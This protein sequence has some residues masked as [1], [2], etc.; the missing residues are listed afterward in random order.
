MEHTCNPDAGE[1]PT[2]PSPPVL[3]F[4]SDSNHSPVILGLELSSWPQ[5]PFSKLRRALSGRLDTGP[6]GTLA[7]GP[8][9]PFPWCHRKPWNLPGLDAV[10]GKQR[11][12]DHSSGWVPE[13]GCPGR[14][15]AVTPH[16]RPHSQQL[17]VGPLLVGLV[18][19]VGDVDGEVASGVVVHDV[20]H[21]RDD[22]V[23]LHPVLQLQEEPGGQRLG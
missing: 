1:S 22:D 15:S 11:P 19:D 20:T 6:M 13:A 10:A 7:D 21:V 4:V 2:R 18:A 8:G 16:P 5:T 14:A 3:A 23:F 9:P 12:R 17:L